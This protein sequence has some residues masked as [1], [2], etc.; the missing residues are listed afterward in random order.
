VAILSGGRIVLDRPA[1]EL[2]REDLHRLY[3]DLALG[4]GSAP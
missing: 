2:G 3:D 1:A 4:P